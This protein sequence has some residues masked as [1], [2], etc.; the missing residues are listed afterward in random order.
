MVEYDKGSFD[1]WCVYL[2]RD[3]IHYAPKDTEYFNFFNDLAFIYGAEKVYNDF[4]QVYDITDREID[5]KVLAL[6]SGIAGTYDDMYVDDVDMWMTIIYAGMVAEENKER[7]YLRRRV[8][9][10]GMYQVLMECMPG[11]KAAT[12]SKG[13]KWKELDAIM[14]ERGF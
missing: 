8:K 13:K 10:L 7:T 5:D 1:E 9:R 6:I 4:L 11:W 3:G 14:V 12:F 2:T